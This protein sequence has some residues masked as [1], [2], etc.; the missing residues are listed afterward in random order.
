MAKFDCTALIKEAEEK[1]MRGCGLSDVLYEKR[2]QEAYAS[3]LAQAPLAERDATEQALKERGFDPDFEPYQP[4]AGEC[5][6]TGIDIDCCPC[7]RHP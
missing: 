3:I 7:G 6:L 5:S 1:A 4:G 2:V